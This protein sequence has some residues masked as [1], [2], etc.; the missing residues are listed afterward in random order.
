MSP[1]P[2]MSYEDRATLERLSE[3]LSAE[4]T[5]GAGPPPEEQLAALR[6]AVGHH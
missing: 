1:E 2:G 3:A 6:Q 5:E 4:T